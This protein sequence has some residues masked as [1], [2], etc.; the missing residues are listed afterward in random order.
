M[1]SSWCAASE[2]CWILSARL[3]MGK[4]EITVG[5]ASVEKSHGAAPAIQGGGHADQVYRVP[6]LS[7]TILPRRA[8]FV[9]F[10]KRLG[11]NDLQSQLI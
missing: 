8:A 4:I 5:A 11:C 1:S 10:G 7:T 9:T 6:L 2:N 3:E